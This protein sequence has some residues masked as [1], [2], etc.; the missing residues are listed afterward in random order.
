MGF[1]TVR[2][3]AFAVDC[4]PGGAEYENLTIAD[5]NHQIRLRCL[6]GTSFPGAFALERVLS[7]ESPF[8]FI[9]TSAAGNYSGTPDLDISTDEDFNGEG[10]GSCSW[11][12][13]TIAL[14]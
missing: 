2:G 7:R 12:E 10:C 11:A 1:R 6:A 8:E 3:Q 5:G 9:I 13:A 4:L 14:Q